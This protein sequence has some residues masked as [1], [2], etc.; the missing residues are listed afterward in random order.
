MKLLGSGYKT[1]TRIIDGVAAIILELTNDSQIV[2]VTP[3]GENYEYAYT[4]A[5]LYEGNRL[6]T[7]N[8]TYTIQASNGVIGT[9]DEHKRIYTVTQLEVDS[10]RVNIKAT[11][12]GTDYERNFVITKVFSGESTVLLDITNDSHIFASDFNGNID[13][14]ASI[15]TEVVMYRGNTII[16]PDSVTWSCDNPQGLLIENISKTKFR[17]TALKG[18]EMDNAG[19]IV[20]TARLDHKGYKKEFSW[21]KVKNGKPGP[22]GPIGPQGPQGSQGPSGPRGPQGQ[23]GPA[24]IQGPQGPKGDKG[25]QGATGPQGVQGPAGTDGKTYYTWIKYANSSTGSGMS[26]DPTDKTYIGFAYNKTTPTESNNAS[27]YTWSLIK[28]DK[29]DTGVQGPSGK[30]GTTT[31]TWIKY[32]DNADGTGLYDTPKSTTKYIG[33]ATNKTTATESTTKTDYTWSLF[34]GDKGD[35]GSQGPQGEKGDTGAQG[36]KGDTGATGVGISS[37]TNYYLATSSSS[38]VTTS[39]S[40]WTTGVQNVT[41]TNKYLWNYE[42]V[43]YTNNSTKSTVPCIIGAY[44]DKGATGSTGATGNGIASITEHYQVSTSN[45]TA[46]TTWQS[47]VPT[48]TATNKYLWNYETIK[49]TDNST[50]DTLKRVIGVYGDKGATGSQGP[51][52]EKGDTGL[53]G[54]KGPQGPKGDKGPQGPQGIMGPPGIQGPPGPILDWVQDWD[55][56]KVSIGSNQ[57]ISPRI[58]AGHLESNKPTGV[59]IGK[60]IFGTLNGYGNVSGIAGY[61]AGEKTFH[62]QTNG[63]FLIGDINNNHLYYNGKEFELRASSIM[64]GA[65]EVTT[66]EVVDNSMTQMETMLSDNVD[67]AITQAQDS[68]LQNVA[69]N[70]APNSELISLKQ[71][72]S[73]NFEQ[74]N[75]NI[76][77]QFTTTQEY[78]KEVDGKLQD[79]QNTIGTNIRFSED[80][81]E[82]GKTNSPFSAILNNEKLSFE[83]DNEE[84]AYISNNKMY[85]TNAEVKETLRIG[86]ESNGFFSWIQGSNGN[87]SLKWSDK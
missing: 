69:D 32:S 18:T 75:K 2:P 48:L 67:N 14:N 34:K 1:L 47:T 55:D 51:K 71:T 54:P 40:G 57:L 62:L 73:S 33:I 25:P 13:K 21:I 31:Y 61:K 17:I 86:N 41:S 43:K 12:K 3:N 29:G 16:E 6:I 65:S 45:S 46:P 36:P 24:G 63:D 59:A 26:N 28:G 76:E 10:G 27:D 19:V 44:G 72:V 68:I 39:T 56:T 85:I 52:G 9:W 64:L 49:Y 58:F 20:F 30:D 78:T 87:L 79:F 15:I 11:Y 7:S 5:N 53:Q 37:I 66:R 22:S 23:Q 35:T 84:V 77:M 42:V 60:N 70:Y 81:I 80:G 8:V 50:K 38:G 82:L 74:T 83:Q 4:V